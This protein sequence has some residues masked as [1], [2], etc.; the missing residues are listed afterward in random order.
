MRTLKVTSSADSQIHQKLKFGILV[1]ACLSNIISTLAGKIGSNQWRN[2]QVINWF[3]NLAHKENR[4]LIK[5]DIT[6]FYP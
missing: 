3:K 4:R 1:L 5:F 6:D 2:T